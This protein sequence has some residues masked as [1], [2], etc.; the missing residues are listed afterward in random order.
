MNSPGH[1]DEMDN[2]SHSENEEML[3][4]ASKSY[5]PSDPSPS[6][7]EV[8]EPVVRKVAKKR[9]QTPDNLFAQP[10]NID[11][12]F[13]DNIGNDK[14]NEAGNKVKVNFI[15]SNDFKVHTRDE[16]AAF[17]DECHQSTEL[18]KRLNQTQESAKRITDRFNLRRTASMLAFLKA[19]IRKRSDILRANKPAITMFARVEPAPRYQ[20]ALMAEV[21]RLEAIVK[22]ESKNRKEIRRL[23]M[24]LNGVHAHGVHSTNRNEKPSTS[25]AD[26][27]LARMSDGGVDLQDDALVNHIETDKT[28]EQDQN[29]LLDRI[30]MLEREITGKI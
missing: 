17:V 16:I 22:V 7:E 11:N 2:D 25:H 13:L 30:K 8:N 12:F 1:V 19:F 20:V 5:A 10:D 23:R 3:S 27:E 18:S 28:A 24:I 4:D 21:K 6:D 9:K 15:Q 29:V 14:V 26:E